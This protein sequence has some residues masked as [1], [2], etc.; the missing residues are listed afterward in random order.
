MNLAMDKAKKEVAS[1]LKQPLFTY[2]YFLKDFL[3]HF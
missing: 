1:F 3:T 2:A